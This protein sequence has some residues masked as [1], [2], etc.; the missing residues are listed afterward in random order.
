MTEPFV[1][2]K[3]GQTILALLLLCAL[4]LP[5]AAAS[6]ADVNA[7]IDS[8]LSDHEG[9]AKAFKIL[10]ANIDD[11]TKMAKEYEYP[12]T[13]VVDGKEVAFATQEDFVAGYDAMITPAIVATVK[14]QKYKDLTVSSQGVMFGSGQ[15]WVN[16]FCLDGEDCQDSSWDISAV[17]H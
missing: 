16:E 8:V 12:L 17:N 15:L 1:N 7:K 13:V 5:A 10:Q 9:F 14:K 11:G 6:A 4:P 3:T 2:N